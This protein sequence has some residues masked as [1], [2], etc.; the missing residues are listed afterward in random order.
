MMYFSYSYTKA[1]TFA[2]CVGH[3]LPYGWEECIDGQIGTYYVDHINSE[4][5]RQLL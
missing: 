5:D 4:S 2:D 1:Q 3:E